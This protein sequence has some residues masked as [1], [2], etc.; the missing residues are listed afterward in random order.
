MKQIISYGLY[1][2]EQKYLVGALKNVALAQKIYP[3]YTVRFYVS[4]DVPQWLI[5]T[6]EQFQNVEIKNAPQNN[7]WFSSAWRF[8]AF[9]DPEVDLV[10]IRNVDARLTVRERRAHDDWLD[11]Q[12]DFHVMKD[13]PNHKQ[14]VP[15]GMWSG[16][17]DKL[18]NVSTL[19][20]V[21]IQERKEQSAYGADELFIRDK[22]AEKILRNCMMHDSYF[23]TELNRPSVRK[24]FPTRLQNPANHVGAA[25]DENDF[26]RYPTDEGLSVLNGGSGRFEYDLDLL[27]EY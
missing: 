20:G 16:W 9:A 2:S 26:F 18:R 23:E 12:L 1:G 4:D 25:L 24:K 7:R 8:L 22:L 14:P 3:E 27:E 6:L 21:F 5:D 13:H 11:S 17:A 15:A 10:L 19:M